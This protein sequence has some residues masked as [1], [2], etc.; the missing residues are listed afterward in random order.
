MR[1]ICDNLDKRLPSANTYMPYSYK[2]AIEGAR[3]WHTRQEKGYLS[4][5]DELRLAELIQAARLEVEGRPEL[6]DI[7]KEAANVE[8]RMAICLQALGE[9]H[10]ARTA[11]NKLVE[12]HLGY[13]AYIARASMNI[14][15]DNDELASKNGRK[16]GAFGDITKLKSSRAVLADRVQEA[17]LGLI[18]AAWN[19]KANT[20][21]RRG[22]AASIYG[23]CYLAHP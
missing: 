8:E 15:T 11:M 22:K 6:K 20:A 9:S 10:E 4:K 1:E 19:Y 2:K 5:E 18:E 14:L 3:E 17:N 16:L 7:L 23:V 21:G 13:A 12:V